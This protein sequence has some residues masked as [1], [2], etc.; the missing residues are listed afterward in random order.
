MLI[1]MFL[2]AHLMKFPLPLTSFHLQLQMTPMYNDLTYNNLT[3]RWYNVQHF[4]IE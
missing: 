2:V 4:I 3:L 1:I